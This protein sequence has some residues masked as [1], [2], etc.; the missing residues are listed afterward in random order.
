MKLPIVLGLLA[1]ASSAP[2][3]AGLGGAA[4]SPAATGVVGAKV[5]RQSTSTD[6]YTVQETTAED[7]TTVREY[8]LSSGVVFAVAWSGPRMPNLRQ[9]LGSYFESYRDEAA[10]RS[11]GRR[12]IAIDRPDL[13]VQ[14]GGH[15]RAFHGRAY[16][17]Q[18][19]P[20]GVS[21]DDI[22]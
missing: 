5:M 18:R 14:S 9:L 8:V 20:A 1:L 21:S 4:M 11:P 2:A 15:P 17:P 3:C 13:V 22:K 7:G 12:P 10:A 6:G 16:L 19:M